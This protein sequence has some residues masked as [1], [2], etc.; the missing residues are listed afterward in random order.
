MVL[1]PKSG[2][3]S[4][5]SR[6][7]PIFPSCGRN[8]SNYPAL[9]IEVTWNHDLRGQQNILVKYL[10]ILSPLHLLICLPMDS[11]HMIG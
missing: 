10:G 2:P 7:C 3:W 11:L 1:S 8:T 6:Q 5:C 4:L 9:E